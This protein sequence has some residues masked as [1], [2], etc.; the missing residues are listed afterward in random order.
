MSASHS[1]GFKQGDKI[2]VFTDPMETYTH[3]AFLRD[4]PTTDRGE[5]VQGAKR[6]D[7]MRRS[8]VLGFAKAARAIIASHRFVWLVLT[9]A[10]VCFVGANA[11]SAA[12]ILLDKL[13]VVDDWLRR[14][15]GVTPVENSVGSTCCYRLSVWLLYQSQTLKFAKT[16]AHRIVS[17]YRTREQ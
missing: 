16:P 13:R 6:Y 8:T 5:H 9:G 3:P 15:Q 10:K 4:I 14:R 2:G 1:A 7:T 17:E 12:R 11:G